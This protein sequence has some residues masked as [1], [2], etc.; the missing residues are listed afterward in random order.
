MSNHTNGQQER[1]FDEK[2]DNNNYSAVDCG[3]HPSPSAP[4][5]RKK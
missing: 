3:R 4:M 1:Q 5:K 2:P